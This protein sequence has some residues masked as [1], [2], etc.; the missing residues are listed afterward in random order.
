MESQASAGVFTGGRSADPWLP[1]SQRSA[2]YLSLDPADR[3]KRS[4]RAARLNAC[5]RASLAWTASG[6]GRQHQK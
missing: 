1:L 4:C 2:A 5:V 3:A 6:R